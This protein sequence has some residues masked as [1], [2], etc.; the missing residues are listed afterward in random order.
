M[1][2]KIS[3]TSIREDAYI[4]YYNMYIISYRTSGSLLHTSLSVGSFDLNLLSRSQYTL[5]GLCS[6]Q[7]SSQY[8]QN[9]PFISRATI[10]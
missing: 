3:T 1:K 6:H 8:E 7:Y 10:R 2:K 5:M 9:V 4:G